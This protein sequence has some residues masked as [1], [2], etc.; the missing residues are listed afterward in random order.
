[1]VDWYTLAGQAEQD[2]A[3]SHDRLIWQIL[4]PVILLIFGYV[5]VQAVRNS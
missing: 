5:I 3:A 1:M 4:Y 2:T